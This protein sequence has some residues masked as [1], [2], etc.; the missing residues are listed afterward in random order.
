MIS[1][2]RSRR[3]SSSS[4][5]SIDI[6]K[7]TTPKQK[8]IANYNLSKSFITSPLE[9]LGLEEEEDNIDKA[10]NK[11]SR[12]PILESS[13]IY[14]RGEEEDSTTRINLISS[15]S[16]ASPTKR[17]RLARKEKARAT[18]ISSNTR[19]EEDNISSINNIEDIILESKELEDKESRRKTLR[20]DIGKGPSNITISSIRSRSILD[21]SRLASID[22]DLEKS[23][24]TRESLEDAFTL[25]D[26]LPRI[27]SRKEKK[28]FISRGRPRKEKGIG[29][30][31]QKE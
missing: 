28:S 21:D 6:D 5:Y 10:R 31:K 22:I 11:S 13:P 8:R 4:S 17:L 30:P 1:K 27:S 18:S 15:S 25:E 16:E 19:E 9:G 3:S 20:E 29:R 12:L 2:A 24:L 14:S 26:S 7:F 23:S